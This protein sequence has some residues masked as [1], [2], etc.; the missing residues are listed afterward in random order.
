MKL[1]L[2][3]FLSACE[4]LP[5]GR[6]VPE[7][8]FSPRRLWKF[9][10]AWQLQRIALEVEGG[11]FGT[12]KPCPLC[13]RRGVAGHSSIERIKTDKDKYNA[14]NLAGWMVLR[15]FPEDIAS[16]AALTLLERAG[17]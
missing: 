13:G 16:G 7:F 3:T 10:F 17:T 12:G 15:C 14:A 1:T 4:T 2:E 6:P 11:M 8:R 9:D 5:I